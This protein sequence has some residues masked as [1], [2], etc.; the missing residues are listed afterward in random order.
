MKPS[1][2]PF[3]SFPFCLVDTLGKTELEVAAG[4]LVM[5]CA[6]HGDEW[7]PVTREQVRE[8]LR[9]HVE[10]LNPFAPPDFVGLQRLG[11]ATWHAETAA[12]QLTPKCL[13]LIERP[14]AWKAE[15]RP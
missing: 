2:V 8:F 3:R 1:A 12:L 15:L 13:S 7:Q 10:K 14:Q 4:I 6:E 5:Y 9:E 11:L